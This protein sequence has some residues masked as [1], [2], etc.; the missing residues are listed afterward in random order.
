MIGCFFM[1]RIGIAAERCRMPDLWGEPTALTSESGVLLVVSE[2]AEPYGVRPGQKSAG[3]RS[4]CPALNLL[5]YDGAIYRQA[6]E[7]IWNGIA[8]E[9]SVVEPVSAELCYAELDDRHVTPVLT[10]FVSSLS[11]AA[12]MPIQA[13]VGI[14]K[15]TAR[16][17]AMLATAGD[18]LIIF[19]GSE[20][21]FL[22]DME[23]EAACPVGIEPDLRRRLGKLGLR[24]LGDL[25]TVSYR[26][27]TR[28]AG[29]SALRLSRL[30]I[31]QDGDPV[32]PAWPRPLLTAEY[33]FGYEAATLEPVM[34]GIQHTA[35]RL[36]RTL[37][38]RREFAQR[39]M[40]GLIR[41]DHSLLHGEERLPHA[42][43]NAG[44]LMRAAE[45]ILGRL[46]PLKE[47]LDGLVLTAGE[48]T[49]G[50]AI[51]MEL[52]DLHGGPMPA[53]TRRKLDATLEYLRRRF[54]FGA[55][56]SASSMHR[57]RRIDYWISPYCHRRNE[58]VEVAATPDGRPVRFWRRQK[59][60]S[61]RTI[62]HDWCETT[63][64]WNELIRTT[65]YRIETEPSGLFELRHQGSTWRITA[66]QD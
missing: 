52:F 48:L 39:L 46:G 15:I 54:G 27:L 24:T 44:D 55:V 57:A 23:I 7:V 64:S 17:A 33:R 9:S 6:A 21:R 32:M 18:P 30:A 45:R 42:M 40:L 34:L 58:L 51:Q 37:L 65:I 63:W 62:L 41:S 10:H 12:R 5:P 47:P 16:H 38:A 4:L 26:D 3:A 8:V 53:E 61:V 56:L 59:L 36:E 35:K 28:V 50:T 43:Q 13:G 60:Y 14:S 31:G 49:I 25:Q 20:A 2:E 22:A 1:P 29:K 66:E 11:S 19:P